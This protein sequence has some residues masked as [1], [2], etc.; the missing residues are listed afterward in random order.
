MVTGM[1]N[2]FELKFSEDALLSRVLFLVSST[3]L[4]IFVEDENKEY[5]Y[6]EIFE[7]LFPKELTINCI[8]PT[9]GKERLKEAYSLFGNS[10]EYGKTFFIAD[11]D[12]DLVLGKSMI[13]ADNFIYLNRYNIESYLLNEDAVLQFMRPRLRKTIKETKSIV[14]YQ[15]WVNILSPFFNKLFALHCVVQKYIPEVENVGR[16][17]TQF[18]TSSGLP[19]QD[20]LDQYEKEVGEKIPNV[21]SETEQMLNKL[22]ETYGTDIGA[23]V[24]GK[25]YICSLKLFLNTKLHKKINEDEVKAFL[26]AG[27]NIHAISY[28]KE[29]LFIYIT[30]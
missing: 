8:F 26:I 22:K 9:G 21:I 1:F 28:I 16:N 27:L 6:E 25:Y 30:A 3:S 12:F 5:E 23:F 11:G 2:D 20:Q 14:N 19:N 29:K 24:C 13:N 7:K 17:P 15:N 10:A 4:N 18:L